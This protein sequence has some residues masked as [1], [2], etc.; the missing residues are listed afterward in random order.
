MPFGVI[1]RDPI[2]GQGD[3]EFRALRL[4]FRMGREAASTHAVGAQ[5]ISLK[6]SQIQCLRKPSPGNYRNT[7]SQT[8]I[9]IKQ[10]ILTTFLTEGMLHC[11]RKTQK[12]G[13]EHA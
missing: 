6:L 3:S 5:H 2:A 7:V 11:F 8:I 10:R 4:S 13:G 9:L 12:L 1:K